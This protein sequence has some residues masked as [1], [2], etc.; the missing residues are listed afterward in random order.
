MEKVTLTIGDVAERTRL[1]KKSIYQLIRT[2]QLPAYRPAKNKLVF[3]EDE[4][5]NY[6]K[7]H[8]VKVY[9]GRM[10]SK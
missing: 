5:E 3:F 6:L 2:G 1:S 9:Q 4:V 8:Q 7:K 10:N